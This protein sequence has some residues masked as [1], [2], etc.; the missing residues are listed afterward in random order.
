MTKFDTVLIFW[1]LPFCKNNTGSQY[2]IP[3]KCTWEDC[4]SICQKRPGINAS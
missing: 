3:F 2:I 1:L 4:K